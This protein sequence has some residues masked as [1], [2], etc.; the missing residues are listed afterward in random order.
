[1]DTTFFGFDV[2][3][4]GLPNF[5][6]TSAAAP[7]AAAVAALVIQAAGGPGRIHPDKVYRTLQRTATPIAVA[8][9]RSWAAAFAGPVAFSAG[10]DW[11]RWNRYFG[12]AV[13]PFTSRTVKT[14]VFDASSI[15]LT[16]SGI[17]NRFH[18][19]P[20]SGLAAS[21]ISFAATGTTLTLRFKPGTFGA[22]DAF[23]FGMSVVNPLQ[24]T[25][26]QDPDRFRGMTVTV[27]LDNGSSFAGTVFAAPPERINR[28]TGFGLVNAD[29]A[30]RKVQRE[31]DED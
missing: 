13:Q 28:F 7:H 20:A 3:G 9:D 17:A 18:V 27:T 12:L 15:G 21:D 8:N 30:V 2:E 4:N 5:F 10:G 24:K 16:W 25:T 1:V 14:V 22:G 26:Q 11:T 29:A 19:G 31:R 23:K 6:G